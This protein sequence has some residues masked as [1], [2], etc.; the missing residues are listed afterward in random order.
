MGAK[1]VEKAPDGDLGVR[2]RPVRFALVPPKPRVQT[3]KKPRGTPEPD[4]GRQRRLLY[5]LAG[6]GLVALVVATVVLA[7]TGGSGGGGDPEHVR[8]AAQAAGCT[9]RSVKAQPRSHSITSPDGTAE[10]NTTPPTTGP[11]YEGTAV[12]GAFDSALQPARYV[13]NLEHGGIFI[14]YGEGVSDA[15]VEQLR[16]FYN[17][18]ERGT[19][20]APLDSLKQQ[21]AVGAWVTPSAEELDNGTSYLMKCTRFDEAAFS[22]FFDELQFQGPERFPA[23]S[24]LPGT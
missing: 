10:W 8:V 22:A 19:L 7:V 3:P 16:A 12:W 20:L 14:Q 4:R 5:A 17:E 6:S 15:T 21:I 18:H 1:S 2:T 9:F 23:D 24:L 11:H 13:H